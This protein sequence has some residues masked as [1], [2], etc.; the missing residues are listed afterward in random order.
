MSCS[1][2]SP[3]SALPDRGGLM[4]TCGVWSGAVHAACRTVTARLRHRRRQALLFLDMWIL[5][6][7]MA[8]HRPVL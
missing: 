4:Y 3:A 7:W 1:L 5:D 6:I 2:G 8:V